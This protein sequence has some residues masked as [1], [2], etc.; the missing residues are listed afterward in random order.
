M[1][2]SS[3]QLQCQLW[4][5]YANFLCLALVLEVILLG[6]NFARHGMRVYPMALWGVKIIFRLIARQLVKYYIKDLATAPP[7]TVE[8]QF[9]AGVPRMY[10]YSTEYLAAAANGASAGS[11]S[12]KKELKY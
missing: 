2:C 1:K 8:A 12:K 7:N 5:W 11:S 10:Q 3:R 9:Y 4:L 6:F